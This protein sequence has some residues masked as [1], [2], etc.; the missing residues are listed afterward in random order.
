VYAATS[1]PVYNGA[2]E[3]A[4]LE[5]A[6]ASEVSHALSPDLLPAGST[7]LVAC[8][9]GADSTALAIAITARAGDL[10]LGVVLGHVDHALRADSHEDAVRVAKLAA[11][12]RVRFRKAR[13]G[14]LVD[15]VRALGLEAAAR[16]ARYAALEMLAREE[17]C[18]R[19][20]TAHTRTDQAETILLRLARGAGPGALAGIRRERVLASG[21]RLVRPL[22][23]VSRAAT[24]T[25]CEKAGVP[26]TRDPHNSDPQRARA[27]LRA[28]WPGVVTALGA[29]LEQA[30]AGSARIASEEDALLGT[31]AAE[32][33]R[34]AEVPGGFDA[35]ALARLP[36][37]LARRCLLAASAGILRP[38]RSHLEQLVGLLDKPRSGID[39]PGGR[40]QVAGGVLRIEQRSNGQ[41]GPRG[42]G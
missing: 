12:L 16:E 5:I 33:L 37:A 39:V 41:K 35:L 24:E 21:A 4:D 36:A 11:T 13:L 32:A 18:D 34:E 14:S 9:G 38:E 7:V 15:E 10:S 29:Q 23:D 17:G 25:L 22:L 6:R 31:L 40:F 1:R 2:M 28:I 27:R 30:L 20:A 26:F 3:M 8:S 19:I 42:R